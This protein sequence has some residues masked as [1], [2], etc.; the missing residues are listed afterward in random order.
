MLA[1]DVM[2]HEV[3]TATPEMPVEAL[4]RLLLEKGVSAVPVVGADGAVLGVASEADLV[5]RLRGPQRRKWWLAFLV[6]REAMARDFVRSHGKRVG[7]V[8]NQPAVTVTEETPVEEIARVLEEHRIKRVP[9][10]RD[11][12]LV[13]IVSRRDLV[14]ALAMRPAAAPVGGSLTDAEID[15]QVSEELRRVEWLEWPS[16]QVTVADGLV[17]LVGFVTHTEVR[18]ALRVLV[19]NI[20]GVRGVED[21]L[22]VRRR[23][24]TTEL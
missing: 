23:M 20:P 8:M 6:D 7:D 12:R 3:V 15:R 14:R 9:V 21:Q 11:D 24:P 13:G 17:R 22:R 4:T 10:V 18:R 19:E 2:T 5:R 16:V 1:R